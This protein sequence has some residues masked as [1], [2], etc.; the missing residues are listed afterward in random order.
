MYDDMWI[1]KLPLDAFVRK[2]FKTTDDVT[3]CFNNIAYTNMRC[4]YVSNLI[5][6]NLGKKDK[7]EAGERLICRVY[8]K[9]GSK[10]FNVNYRFKIVS[11]KSNTVVL[12]NV[13]SKEQYTT[14][15]L[16]LDKHFRYDYCTTCHSAQGASINGKIIIHEW[17]K[18]HLVTRE[19][20]W[21]AL[22]RST[23]F[24]DVLFYESETDK[25]ELTEENLN[26]Y[27]NNKIRNYKLQ[28][29]KAG[30]KVNSKKYVTPEWFIKRINGNCCN[31][32]CRFEFEV[33]N[34]YLTNTITAQRKDNSVAHEVDNCEA[35]CDYC[36]RS[37]K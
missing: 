6:K 11:I 30:R 24:N 27:I 33:K 19:W 17:N 18:K 29:E 10:R 31:C 9:F 1:H 8:K 14:D 26:R 5:R 22:T 7:Y 35:W 23:D 34:G 37:A 12:E 32:G 13:K 28:D 4:L 20:I 21:C 2:Y 3:Q 25:T 16:T 36:N 15:M